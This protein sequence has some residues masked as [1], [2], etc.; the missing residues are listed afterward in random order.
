MPDTPDLALVGQNSVI[1]LNPVPTKNIE[2]KIEDTVNC[3]CVT[4]ARKN[5]PHQPP[6]IGF[7]PSLDIQP[8]QT[9]PKV[10]GWVLTNEGQYGHV[11]IVTSITETEIYVIEKNKVP[12]EVTS[13]VI[14]I[15]NP[16]IR[17]YYWESDKQVL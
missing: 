7:R 5:S 3:S 1:Q 8:N 17:G 14:S 11:A 15:D 10:G 13:R 16:I 4:F 12:C 9:E 6:V 2:Q